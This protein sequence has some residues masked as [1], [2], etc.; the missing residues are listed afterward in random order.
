MRWWWGVR[1][2]RRVVGGRTKLGCVFGED[3]LGVEDCWEDVIERVGE[4]C[5]ALPDGCVAV[6]CVPD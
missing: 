5:G 3:I 2:G 4:R 6:D 1:R